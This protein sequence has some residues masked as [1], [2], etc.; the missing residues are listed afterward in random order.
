V[1]RRIRNESSVPRSR[2]AFSPLAST[3]KCWP[4]KE[5]TL[6]PPPKD[7]TSDTPPDASQDS[8]EDERRP[9]RGHATNPRCDRHR[10]TPS[11]TGPPS[12]TAPTDQHLQVGQR[13]IMSPQGPVPS[14][15]LHSHLQRQHRYPQ[16][17]GRSSP[18][19]FRDVNVLL[20]WCRS[21]RCEHP[22]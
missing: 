11:H 20:P 5:K 22:P 1:P 7:P 12:L 19:S 8:H 18:A 2:R 4:G 17:G 13:C 16:S 21:F 15:A 14:Q 10:D 3:I 6:R 9:R